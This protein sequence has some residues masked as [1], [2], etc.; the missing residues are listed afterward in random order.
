MKQ[1]GIGILGLGTVGTGLC[2]LIAENQE[3]IEKRLGLSLD[4]K[5]AL[6]RD[7]KRKRILPQGRLTTDPKRI[8]QDPEIQII[9]EVMGGMQPAKD[10]I[11]QALKAGKTVVT[12]NKELIARSGHELLTLATETGQDLYFEASVA[13][14]IPIIRTL[15]ESLTAN[16]ISGLYGIINGTTNYILSKM[17]QQGSTLEAALAKAQEQGYAEADPASDIE[18]W[19]AAYKLAILASIA[20]G[21]RVEMERVHVEG[22]GKIQPVDLKYCQ[23]LGYTLK[24]LAIGKNS[25]AG[26]EVRVHP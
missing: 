20:F 14:G 17:S 8:L 1:I 24:L 9:V 16:K 7:L 5:L 15:K 26:I 18:G 12:A 19:D 22:I 13:G 2:K 11:I 21:S 10:L 3:L 25:P 4:L 23:D 6:V